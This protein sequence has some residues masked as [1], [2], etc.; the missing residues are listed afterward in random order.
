MRLC[1]YPYCV[2]YITLSYITPCAKRGLVLVAPGR[3]PRDSDQVRIIDVEPKPQNSSTAWLLVADMCSDIDAQR[4]AAG[5]A[6]DR[7]YSAG[8]ALEQAF[9][10]ARKVADEPP[11]SPKQASRLTCVDCF[12]CLHDD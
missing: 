5:L 4:V 3:C 2:S 7:L 9:S 8:L 12:P 6:L 11:I 1:W 10:T